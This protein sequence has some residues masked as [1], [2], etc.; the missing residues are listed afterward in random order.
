MVLAEKQKEANILC[1][2]SY[3]S[4]V[5]WCYLK[6]TLGGSRKALKALRIEARALQYPVSKIDW[7]STVQRKEEKLRL[8][9]SWP[10]LVEELIYSQKESEAVVLFQSVQLCYRYLLGAYGS[11][12]L[13]I[14]ALRLVSTS[15]GDRRRTLCLARRQG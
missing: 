10:W 5:A 4:P 15:Q 12:D 3:P 1:T 7:K 6:S 14:K 2:Q 9:R 13:V 8:L 11:Q